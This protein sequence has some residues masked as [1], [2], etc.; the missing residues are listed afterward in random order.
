MRKFL[1]AA[2][3]CCVFVALGACTYPESAVSQ[4]AERPAIVVQG[5]S[6]QEILFIDGLNM[7]RADKFNGR[8]NKLLVEPGR[9]VVQVK[10]ADRV[11]LEQTILVSTGETKVISVAK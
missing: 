8:P 11:L 6:S 2:L 1:L 10:N 4:G 3:Y 5:V 7:G 9:H